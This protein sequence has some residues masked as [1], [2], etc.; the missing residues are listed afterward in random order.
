MAG[1][2]HPTPLIRQAGRSLREEAQPALGDERELAALLDGCLERRRLDRLVVPPAAALVLGAV[3]AQ[4]GDELLL[5]DHAVLQL[6]DLV[7]PA[8]LG[9]SLIH[10]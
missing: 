7:A 6:A 8:I 3:G 10:I 9:L 1:G 2:P 4:L 5:D